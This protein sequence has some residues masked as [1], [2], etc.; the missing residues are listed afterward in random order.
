MDQPAEAARYR[1]QAAL[2][3]AGEPLNRVILSV[4]GQRKELEEVLAGTPGRLQF[5][6]E[7]NRLTLRQAT[8]WTDQGEKQASL[9]R[10]EAGL[11]LFHKAAAHD[12][13]APHPH[14]L[15]GL[16]YLFLG[17]Y[18]EAVESYERTGELAPGWFHCRSDLWLAQQL[19]RGA[20]SQEVFVLWH[21][22]EEGGQ[23]PQEK[24]LLADNGLRQAPDLALLHLARGKVL[25]G[26]GQG[27][28]AEAAFRKGLLCVE[29]SDSQTRL[30]VE[31]ASVVADEAEKKRLL[32]QAV[33]VNGNLV[34]VATARVILAFA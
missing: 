16:T 28:Q 22:V 18:A 19:L 13:F 32:E 24:L 1:R 26:L 17:R 30:L 10:F 15:A 34:A 2:V 25:K 20:L 21:S 4:D 7:R 31:V 6:F 12:P 14:Y 9:G 11:E 29:E 23:R 33:T 5:A 8:A 3:F 27:R